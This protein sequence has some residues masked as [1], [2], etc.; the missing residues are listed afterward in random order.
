MPEEEN[1]GQNFQKIET[2]KKDSHSFIEKEMEHWHDFKRILDIFGTDEARENF[3][4]KCLEYYVTLQEGQKRRL[5]HESGVT[6]IQNYDSARAR[7]HNEIME[8]LQRLSL[9]LPSSSPRKELLRRYANRDDMAELI[10]DY[11]GYSP[12]P[13]KIGTRLGRIREGIEP[14]YY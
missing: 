2:E 7:L 12:P 4:E 3:K 14:G 10:L 5:A 11:F 9:H 8:T 13:K 1:T 6:A